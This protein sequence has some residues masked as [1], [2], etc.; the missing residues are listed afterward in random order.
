MIPSGENWWKEM[1]VETLLALKSRVAI[2]RICAASC[3][4]TAHL[5]KFM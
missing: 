3:G 2:P 4:M 5:Y 1:A